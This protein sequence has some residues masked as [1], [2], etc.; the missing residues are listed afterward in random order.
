MGFGCFNLPTYLSISSPHIFSLSL[1]PL[2]FFFPLSLS[3]F[4]SL[5]IYIYIYLYKTIS[6][7]EIRKRPRNWK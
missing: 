1:P 2:S 6:V 4:P 5:S 3:F 7:K